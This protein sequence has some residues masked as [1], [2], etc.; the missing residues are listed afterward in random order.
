MTTPFSIY[1]HI[2]Y[3]HH[4]CPYCDFNTY[5]VSN[6]PERDYTT[7]LLAE[8]DYRAATDSWKGRSVQTIYFGGGTP[9][10]FSPKSIAEIIATIRGRFEVLDDAE[11]SLEA[12]PGTISHDIL[13]G[14]KDG[15]INR[16]SFGAQSFNTAILRT[17]GR[18]HS[19]E[20]IESAVEAARSAGINNINIDIIYGVPQQTVENLQEDLRR[21]LSLN[22]THISPYGLTIEKGTPF[23][24]RYKKGEL[25]LPPEERV[26][27]MMQTLNEMLTEAGILRYEISNFA[28][29]GKEAAHNLAYWNGDD[30]LGLGAG[31]H[32]FSRLPRNPE[33]YGN[34]WSNLALPPQYIQTA[35][36]KGDASSWRDDLSYQDS[37]FEFFFLGLRK[38]AGVDLRKFEEKFHIPA[39][40]LYGSLIEVLSQEGFLALED[41]Q[42]SL[43]AKGLLLTDSVIENFVLDKEALNN[44]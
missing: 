39:Q 37:M 11:I 43:T 10:L 5:A 4:K 16:V 31:A 27:Q 33:I 40:K 36:S 17:L 19:P 12:N 18:M 6:A 24:L 20:Q 38:I 44:L 42:L 9:S 7:S 15:G 1:L 32:S 13:A 2:P 30:Y 14:F 23:F 21:A 26:I 25:V 22:P 34:R 29:P 3:C 28:K 35:A 8:L 41:S